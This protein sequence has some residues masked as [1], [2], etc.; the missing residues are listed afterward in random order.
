MI[1]LLLFLNDQ[2]W[3]FLIFWHG[4]SNWVNAFDVIFTKKIG[5]AMFF[6]PKVIREKVEITFWCRPVLSR[7]FFFGNQVRERMLFSG[8]IYHGKGQSFPTMGN[9]VF[10]L[11]QQVKQVDIGFVWYCNSD[12]KTLVNYYNKLWT[13][14]P[15]LIKSK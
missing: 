7:F 2:N 8:G 5:F 9:V 4:T 10:Y 3:K 15:I 1:H 12:K 14:L 13:T 6:P 11:Q